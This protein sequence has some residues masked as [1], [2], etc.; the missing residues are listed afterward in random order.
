M[1]GVLFMTQGGTSSDDGE[2]QGQNPSFDDYGADEAT[3]ARLENM[4][5]ID[6]DIFNT[7]ALSCVTGLMSCAAVPCRTPI[8]ATMARRQ[9]SADAAGLLQATRQLQDKHM[10]TVFSQP[11]QGNDRTSTTAS[12]YLHIDRHD[13]GTAYQS[14][15]MILDD[16]GRDPVTDTVIPRGQSPPYVLLPDNDKP[17][18]A[19]T[20]ALH[21]LCSEQE[22]AFRITMGPLELAIS[23]VPLRDVPQLKLAILGTAG[24]IYVRAC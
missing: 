7:G 11:I 16:K 23:G 17:S 12:H 6:D 18:L 4:C 20:V 22:S 19:D 24:E 1:N 14:R 15:V 13:N 5:S 9:T 3:M 2:Y 21:G 10:K 8:P